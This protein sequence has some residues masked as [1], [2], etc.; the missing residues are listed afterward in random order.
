MA[1]F[2]YEMI[3]PLSPD[4]PY[5]KK[6]VKTRSVSDD[7]RQGAEKKKKKVKNAHP[8]LCVSLSPRSVANIRGCVNQPE[9]KTR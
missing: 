4:P 5:T 3:C 9:K 1:L 8:V 6:R 2:D 7:E